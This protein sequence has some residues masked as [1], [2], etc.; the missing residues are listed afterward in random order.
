MSPVDCHW[1]KIDRIGH[2]AVS[3]PM[4]K[5]TSQDRWNGLFRSAIYINLQLKWQGY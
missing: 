1:N 5:N 2:V 3:P 4:T